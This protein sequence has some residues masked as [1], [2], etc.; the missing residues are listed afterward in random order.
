MCLGPLSFLP[1]DKSVT[2]GCPGSRQKVRREGE[3]GEEGGNPCLKRRRGARASTAG[4][5]SGVVDWTR[6]S[7]VRWISRPCKRRRPLRYEPQ[8]RASAIGRERERVR[9]RAVMET[10]V[11]EIDVGV[12]LLSLGETRPVLTYLLRSA[13]G[14]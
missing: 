14:L 11:T 1:D 2:D 4:V 13:N 9:M 8:C 7:G 10:G 3:R 6:W 5:V 12:I